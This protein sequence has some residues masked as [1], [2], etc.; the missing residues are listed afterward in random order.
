MLIDT[1][2]Y[3]SKEFIN[4]LEKR[5]D[6]S[7]ERFVDFIVNL[8]INGEH[9][10]EFIL[11]LSNLTDTFNLGKTYETKQ[12]EFLNETSKVINYILEKIEKYNLEEFENKNNE[13]QTK[14]Y[15]IL[16]RKNDSVY[17]GNNICKSYS[18]F[19]LD[20]ISL[21]LKQGE[22]IGIIGENGCGKST[23]LKI[24]AGEILSDSGQSTYFQNTFS[25]DWNKI[26]NGIGYIR[27]DI[28]PWSNKVTVKKYL[29][30][31]AN[32]KGIKGKN[33]NLAVSFIITRL[34]LRKYEN[35]YWNNLSTGYKLRFELAR[36]LIWNPKLLI[37]DEPLANLDIKLQVSFL[38]MLREF[39]N[40]IKY[41]LSILISSQNIFEL[42]EI[43]DNIIFLQNGKSI[44]NGPISEIHLFSNSNC[45]IFDVDCSIFE[46]QSA[47][48]KI[49]DDIILV[50]EDGIH[51][52]VYTH[53]KITSS[54]ILEI[55]INS[56]IHIK[57][58][59]NISNSSRV[60]FE[61]NEV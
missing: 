56:N 51:I 52:F 29:H 23:L 45:Y 53:K 31:T 9:K 36:Q 13:H 55:V 60:F 25:N 14:D 50:K 11:L 5:P 20:S 49:I 57:Y 19:E 37:M 30:L 10:N 54:Q 18:G 40:S 28:T 32:L 44:Y 15:F 26:K 27:Q 1:S 48:N 43:A 21:N 6:L 33:N 61:N 8:S 58:F 41:P 46:F 7:L 16:K 4:D 35:Y 38:Q 2:F 34:G 3:R 24:I 17:F 22:I 59:R 42:E 12:N 39:A 47:L